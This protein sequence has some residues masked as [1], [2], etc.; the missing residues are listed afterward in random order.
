MDLAVLRKTFQRDQMA[1][2]DFL[3]NQMMRVNV[4]NAIQFQNIIEGFYQPLDDKFF[5]RMKI[6]VLLQ[7]AEIIHSSRQDGPGRFDWFDEK[8][9][10]Q[11]GI[12]RIHN[13]IGEMRKGRRRFG[14]DALLDLPRDKLVLCF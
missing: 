2:D 5:Q 13:F 7:L 9:K 11:A 10:R 8:W 4:V 1:L 12:Q 6:K 14:Y 3:G